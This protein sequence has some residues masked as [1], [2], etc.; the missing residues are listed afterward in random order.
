MKRRVQ[1]EKENKKDGHNLKH[2]TSFTGGG[3]LDG[4]EMTRKMSI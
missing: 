2:L 4:P 1:E 3:S